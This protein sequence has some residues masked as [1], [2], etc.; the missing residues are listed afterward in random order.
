MKR[1]KKNLIMIAKRKGLFLF[2]KKEKRKNA[3]GQC[4]FDEAPGPH[5][6][7]ASGNCTEVDAYHK[8]SPV[9]KAAAIN[10]FF[11]LLLSIYSLPL[12]MSP[13]V[14]LPFPVI[15]VILNSALSTMAATLG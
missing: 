3:I 12:F 9:N 15:L 7:L 6:K 1:K 4:Y 14:G 10:L 5:V 2:Y 13:L 8:T 11:S